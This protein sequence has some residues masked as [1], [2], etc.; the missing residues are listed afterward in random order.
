[1]KKSLLISLL[2]MLSFLW[3]MSCET[4]YP[5][6]IWVEDDAGNPNPVISSLT[7]PDSAF[8]AADQRQEVVINGSNFM[9]DPTANFVYFGNMQGTVN[10]ASTTQLTVTPPAN[11]QSG[12][13]VKVAVHGAYLFG[14]YG[15]EST[16]HPYKLKNPV[17][18]IL[19]YDKY[20]V[21]EGICVDGANNVIITHGK[22]MDK[23]SPSG[24]IRTI[25]EIK[26]KAT[27]N[28]QIGPDGALYYTYTKY[29]MKTDTVAFQHT[30]TKLATN[31][32]D[33]DFDRNDHLYIVG[34][35]AIYSAN[36]SDLVTVVAADVPDYGFNCVRIFNDELYVAGKYKGTDPAVAAGTFIWKYALDVNNGTVTGDRQV[37]L[38]WSTT[39]YA[40]LAITS[41]TFDAAGKIYVG[42]EKYSLL[43]ITPTGSDYATGTIAKVYTSLLG[44]ELAFRLFWGT[45]NTLY[46]S[47]KNDANPDKTKMLKANMFEAGAPYFGRE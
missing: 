44:G 26:A 15:T 18:Q 4:D 17:T 5:P 21:P 35:D 19:G 10:S 23:I 9:D 25:G 16:A 27:N 47:A 22:Y 6:S 11:F 30:N 28:I 3:V 41:M 20:V 8:G 45:D 29:I 13:T 42:T 38:N 24:V 1:M 7:P 46:M 12:L 34:D 32:K 31:V 33:L 43:C 36:Y 37:V 40:G 2:F 39:A 14:T